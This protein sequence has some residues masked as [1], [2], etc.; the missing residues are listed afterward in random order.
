MDA[1]RSLLKILGGILLFT[2]LSL[3]IWFG[4][5]RHGYYA[6]QDEIKQTVEI[7][8]VDS[9]YDTEFTPSPSQEGGGDLVG[10]YSY[11]IY[12]KDS[13][14]NALKKP[15]E[16]LYRPF[17]GKAKIIVKDNKIIWYEPIKQ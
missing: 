12:Y 17:V 10:S 6:A 5:A 8:Q 16:G 11:T 9:V 14:G 4:F 15:I 1:F 13:C 3:P 7:T 2:A